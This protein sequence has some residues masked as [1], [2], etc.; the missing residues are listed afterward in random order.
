M[1]ALLN[2]VF[3]VLDPNP[4]R[5]NESLARRQAVFDIEKHDPRG[6]S[7]LDELATMLHQRRGQILNNFAA[8]DDVENARLINSVIFSVSD[9]I[10]REHGEEDER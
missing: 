5:P 4:R 10:E 6:D 9:A 8:G 2:N 3:R 1:S 7:L